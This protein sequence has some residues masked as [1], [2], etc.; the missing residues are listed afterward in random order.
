MLKFIEIFN[1]CGIWTDILIFFQC[2]IKNWG[3]NDLYYWTARFIDIFT[4]K[5]IEKMFYTML[6]V[7][8]RNS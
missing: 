1:T 5:A 2:L 8:P 4:I 7:I 6:L 3:L